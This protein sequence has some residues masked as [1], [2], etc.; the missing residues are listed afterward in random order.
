MTKPKQI[1]SFVSL[2]LLVFASTSV[3]SQQITSEQVDLMVTQLSNW[4]LSL[5]H[6]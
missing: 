3:E 6:I 2:A 5:I 4:G 1:A